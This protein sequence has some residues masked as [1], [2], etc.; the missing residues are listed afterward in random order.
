[1]DTYQKFLTLLILIL[2]LML[3]GCGSS[4]SQ[5]NGYTDTP[6]SDWQHDINYLVDTL[7]SVHPNLLH[8]INEQTFRQQVSMLF[9]DSLNLSDSRIFLEILK[10][11][12]TIGAQR[13]GHLQMSY[14]AGT[15]NKIAPIKFYLFEEGVFVV[16]ASNDYQHLIGAQLVGI[17]GLPL[18]DV[19]QQIDTILTQDNQSSTQTNR[20]LAYL[21][22]E[23]LY[24]L[25][26]SNSAESSSYDLVLVNSE[27]SEAVT[28]S[29]V[30]PNQYTL[31][32][33]TKLPI[34]PDIKF[35]SSSAPFWM[36]YIALDNL[37]YIKMNQVTDSSNG[38]S[39]SDLA[40]QVQTLTEQ[41]NIERV[42]LDLRQNTGGNNQLVDDIVSF[43]AS[44]TI[45][46]ADKLIVF[47]DRQT[48]SA[49]GNL[50]A[51]IQH[52][53]QATLIG[54]PPGGAG[55]Q[56]GD[57]QRYNSPNSNL[58]VFIPTRYWQFG[59][60]A[61]APLMLEMDQRLALSATDY[62]SGQDALLSLFTQAQ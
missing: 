41:Q 40:Q 21:V 37:V 7:S 60:Q 36:E 8:S 13:D 11:L 2:A 44:P 25:G 1:M 24:Q 5:S 33:S 48:F 62:F 57:T 30:S 56:Y 10:L 17:N 16:Q 38:D 53:T 19:N 49:A 47:T 54:T 34:T 18:A 43:L 4:D 39:L 52:Q 15:D 14:F 42:I 28:V 26:V 46:Q 50:A 20:N 45:N 61:D 22:P 59:N 3:S 31:D 51:E 55:N 29:P 27:V 23:I 58:A 6:T 12:S 9:D 32:A 35:L